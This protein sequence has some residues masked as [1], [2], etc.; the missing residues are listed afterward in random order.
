MNSPKPLHVL[1]IIHNQAETGPYWKV[2]EQCAAYVRLGHRATLLCTSRHLR[3]Q[4][5]ER[6]VEGVRIVEAPDVLWG[7]LRQGVDLWNALW[8][9]RWGRKM[10]TVSS[11]EA[12]DI[13]HAVDC[14]PNVL[15]PALYLKHTLGIPLVL[16]W[17]DMFGSESKRFGALYA[18][19]LG[20]IE[21]WLETA[22]RK[23]ADTSI[24]I[25]HALAK[26]LQGLGI[27][28][29][30]IVV[31]HLGCDSS[32]AVRQYDDAR[33]ML[34]ER[35]GITPDEPVFCFAG[36]IYEADFALLLGA[37]DILNRHN[38]AYRILWIGSYHIS[39]EYCRQY[40]I[41]HLGIV[42][43]MAEVYDYFA[44]ADACLLPM[45]VNAANMARFPSKVT[46]YLNAGCPVALTPISDFPL[47]FEH[48]PEIGWIA[49]SGTP[50]AFAEVLLQAIADR[51]QRSKRS[52]AA[53]AF[54]RQELDSMVIAQRTINLYRT[55][56][57]R[58]TLQPTIQTSAGKNN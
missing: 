22:F 34:W 21:G 54:I 36:T 1:F 11:D 29:D 57:Q 30:R 33:T 46:D 38:T 51:K 56:L 32:V 27:P 8:R 37:L 39:P 12:F 58:H 19:T 23:Y 44:S 13:I 6:V 15:L 24:A 14:R 5:L 35:H 20:R 16:A 43:T 9:C 17:W 31:E 3:W 10:S 18:Y 28:P 40:R 52:H 7:K 53:R 45:E 47:L 50:E 25:T 2:L 49:R 48:Y 42:P 4:A 26:R 55:T 41:I